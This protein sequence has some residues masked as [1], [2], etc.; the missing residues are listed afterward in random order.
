M[1]MRPEDRE[2]AK[3]PRWWQKILRRS[4]N[5]RIINTS[6]GGPNMPK[7]QR[8]PDCGANVKRHHKTHEG[9]VYICRCGMRNYITSPALRNSNR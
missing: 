5:A 8:C 9:A 4:P 1:E 2:E 7:Y 6:R 3:I